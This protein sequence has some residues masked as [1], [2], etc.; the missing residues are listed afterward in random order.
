MPE[1]EDSFSG[2]LK[3]FLMLPILSKRRSPRQI[4]ASRNFSNLL[5][6]NETVRSSEFVVHSLLRESGPPWLSND[7]L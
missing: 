1:A 6:E 4:T 3:F 2:G 7:A 5:S